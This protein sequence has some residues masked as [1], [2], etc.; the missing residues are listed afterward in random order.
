MD[1]GPWADKAAV[2][3]SFVS[4]PCVHSFP[5]GL[6]CLVEFIWHLANNDAKE[7]VP[8]SLFLF[9]YLFTWVGWVLVAVCGI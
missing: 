4:F 7:R 1:N 6:H 9:K 8:V 3:G 2:A 5:Q